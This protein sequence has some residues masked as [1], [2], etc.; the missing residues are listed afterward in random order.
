MKYFEVC[1][2]YQVGRDY[3]YRIKSQSAEILEGHLKKYRILKFGV[4][5]I[6]VVNAQKVSFQ[7]VSL[8]EGLM[9]KHFL[10][11]DESESLE[12]GQFTFC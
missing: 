11:V 2:S 9:D 3:I 4:L 5:N 1:F 8:K 7:E 12:Y 6:G 10:E